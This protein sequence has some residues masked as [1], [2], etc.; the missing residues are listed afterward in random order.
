MSIKLN[1]FKNIES[2]FKLAGKIG[3]GPFS[4]RTNHKNPSSSPLQL[5]NTK[6]NLFFWHFFNIYQPAY[7]IFLWINLYRYIEWYIDQS[8]IIELCLHSAF[9]IGN[10]CGIVL[11][12]HQLFYKT[13]MLN[14]INQMFKFAGNKVTF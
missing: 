13:D 7:T 3:A 6:I 4:W 5:Q 11:K 1:P 14:S 12:T 9:S 2:F 8:H 10:I